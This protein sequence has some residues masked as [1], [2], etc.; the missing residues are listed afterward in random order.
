MKNVKLSSAACEEYKLCSINSHHSVCAAVAARDAAS[1][2]SAF[3]FTECGEIRHGKPLTEIK[4]QNEMRYFFN[5][6]FSLSPS[7][8]S[9][10]KRGKRK[11]NIY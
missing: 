2:L 10:R 7:F 3:C 9:D 8:R 5:T 11:I 1:L 6:L 4:K